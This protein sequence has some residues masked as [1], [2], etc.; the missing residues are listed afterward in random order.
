MCTYICCWIGRARGRC[1]HMHC[2]LQ[3]D[4]PS[5]W[6]CCRRST[7]SSTLPI[8]RH[9]SVCIRHF[10]VALPGHHQV[11]VALSIWVDAECWWSSKRS[12]HCD[13]VQILGLQVFGE[14]GRELITTETSFRLLRLLADSTRAFED[15]DAQGAATHRIRSILHR[16]VFKVTLM[17]MLKLWVLVIQSIEG[18]FTQQQWNSLI[19]DID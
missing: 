9:V 13:S 17:M 6:S 10:G 2:S 12:L 18:C 5:A 4:E 19:P 7:L 16:S 1:P 15:L 8:V 14:H 11:Y 3:I